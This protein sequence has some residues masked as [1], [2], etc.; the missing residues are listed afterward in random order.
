MGKFG[1]SF[2]EVLI[3]LESWMGHR[4]LPEKS[5][6]VSNRPG[7]CVQIGTSPVSEGVQI[8]VGCQFVGSMFRS[9]S[10]LPGGLSR[11]IPGS[12]G[13]QLSRLRHLGWLQCSHGLSCRP[14]ES[15]L[16]GC[17]GPLLD[18]MGY[19]AGAVG[20]LSNKVLR[21]RYYTQPFAKRFPPWSIGGGSP[22]F[23]D[24]HLRVNQGSLGMEAHHSRPEEVN[25]RPKRVCRRLTRKT[26]IHLIRDR[27]ASPPP[28]RRK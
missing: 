19:P 12:Q 3:L 26:P 27:E 17:L 8:R 13:P 4:L 25:D 5:V 1:V 7:R 24:T 15:S 9:L 16:P 21:I 10:K 2:L 6:P 23:R 20:A 11:F 22:G 18:L 28:K 14:L